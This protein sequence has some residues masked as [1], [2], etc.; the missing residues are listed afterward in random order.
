MSFSHLHNQLR[1]LAFSNQLSMVSSSFPDIVVCHL[2][3][4]KTWH[5]TTVVLNPTLAGTS[6]TANT[7]N[8]QTRKNDEQRI[9]YEVLFEVLSE[10]HE[11]PTGR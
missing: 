11:K 6:V 9:N 8:K 7:T 4:F 1:F 2:R 5:E 10:T 3:E